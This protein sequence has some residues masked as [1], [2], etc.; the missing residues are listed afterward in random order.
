MAPFTAFCQVS[1]SASM[2]GSLIISSRLSSWAVT[3]YKMFDL[4]CGVAVNSTMAQGLTRACISR[5]RPVT[6]LCASSTII[7]GRCRCSR[8]AK[9]NLMSPLS[10]FSRPDAA[11]GTA[12]KCG[13]S[14]SLWAYTLR[15]SVLF[16]RSVWMVPTTMQQWSRRSCGRMWVKSAMSNTRTRPANAS[17]NT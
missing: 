5:V 10:I 8:L 7:R 13:S 4:R 12:E 2:M 3:L 17:S 6:A 1:Y 14:S 15:P 11:C 9:E 16:T